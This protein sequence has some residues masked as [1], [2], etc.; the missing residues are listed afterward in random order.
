MRRKKSLL[1]LFSARLW[2]VLIAVLSG[3]AQSEDAHRANNIFAVEQQHSA[4]WSDGNTDVIPDLY[5][6]DYVGHFPGGRLIYGHEGIQSTIKNHR[7]SF[8]DWQESVE[9]IFADGDFVITHFRSVGTHQGEFLGIPA[10]GNKVE[11]SETCIYRLV[12][13][14]IAEQWVYPDI[15]SLQ[16]QLSSE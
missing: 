5:A 15:A 10:T 6:E 8:P 11:I 3:C 9:Q 13:G 7:L 14:K 1:G 16:A 4:V 2:I 12:D